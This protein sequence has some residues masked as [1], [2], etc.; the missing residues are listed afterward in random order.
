L[1]PDQRK[2]PDCEC[3]CYADGLVVI[4]H[5]LLNR[6]RFLVVQAAGTVSYS[7]LVHNVFGTV[8]LNQALIFVVSGLRQREFRLK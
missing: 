6:G 2:R 3:G 1:N 7:R 5:R 8:E 4:A